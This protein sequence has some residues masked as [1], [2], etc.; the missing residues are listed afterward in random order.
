MSD[1]TFNVLVVDDETSLLQFYTLYLENAG[2]RVTTA[3]HGA[4]ALAAIDDADSTFDLIF[5]DVNMP[6][7]D[8][9]TLCQTLREAENYRNVPFVFVSALTTLEEKLHGY[10][11]GGTDYVPKPVEPQELLQKASHLI[12][13][14]HA[15]CSLNAQL[16]ESVNA[17]M[18]AMTYSSQLGQIVEFFKRSLTLHD[19]QSVT[20][21]LFD[22]L[23]A[24]SL[25]GSIQF[26][27]PSGVVSYGNKGD[28]SPLECNVMEMARSKGRFYDFSS[29]TIVNHD[30][31]SLLIKNM[32]IDEIERYGVL[33]D[34]L[35]T[36]CEAVVARVKIFYAVDREKQRETILTTVQGAIDQM[37]Q[38]LASIQKTNTD[39][40]E[41]MIHDI[42]DAMMSL[43]LTEEQETHIRGIAD[44]CLK[45]V[46]ESFSMADKLREQ[47]QQVQM[48]LADLLG[49][50]D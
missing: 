50:M 13:N 44:R 14:Y 43:G 20:E 26:Y 27:T 11:A 9:Y 18:Q 33:K 36:L 49:R 46:D 3:Q 24:N 29:R 40:I 10:D 22:Y 42:D 21:L 4:E 17:A 8:G 47:F 39:A 45:E 48:K 16:S 31:L 30:E 28:V 12:Q 23:N 37:G 25:V 32:P 38:S 5:S 1:N 41:N 6:E 15:Q 19:L 7:M 35:A 2:Y 34:T